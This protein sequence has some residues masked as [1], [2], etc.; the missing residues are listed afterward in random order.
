M[1]ETPPHWLGTLLFS[2]GWISLVVSRVCAHVLTSCATP[3]LVLRKA[4][5]D[6]SLTVVHRILCGAARLSRRAIHPLTI[7]TSRSSLLCVRVSESVQVNWES[8][9]ATRISFLCSTPSSY[10]RWRFGS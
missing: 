8:Q 9:G 3:V 10:I 6:V 1:N 5:P 7:V 2:G 4:V